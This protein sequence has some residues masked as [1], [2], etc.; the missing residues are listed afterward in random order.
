MDVGGLEGIVAALS[1]TQF[2]LSVGSRSY[3]RI[4]YDPGA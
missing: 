1:L 3:G 2:N 4:N